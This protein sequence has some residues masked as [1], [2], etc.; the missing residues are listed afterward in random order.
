[1]HVA[2]EAADKRFVYFKLPCYF[3][4][5]T[6]LHREPD[7]VIHEPRRFLRHFQRPMNLV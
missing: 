1:V 2:G 4:E 3:L 5:R 7:A 6:G